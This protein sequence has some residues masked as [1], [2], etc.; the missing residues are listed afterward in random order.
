MLNKQYTESLIQA[1]LINSQGDPILG[2]LSK[3]QWDKEVHKIFLGI[4]R[5]NLFK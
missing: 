5:D 1:G 3:E 2:A 4:S